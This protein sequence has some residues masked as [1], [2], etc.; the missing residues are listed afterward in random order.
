M[1]NVNF[2]KFV[3]VQFEDETSGTARWRYNFCSRGCDNSETQ[4][5]ITNLAVLFIY[6]AEFVATNR[7]YLMLEALI[8]PVIRVL[9]Q[10]FW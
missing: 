1:H 2:Q 5:R 8:F 4:L 6:N 9:C 7:Y 3:I 10:E